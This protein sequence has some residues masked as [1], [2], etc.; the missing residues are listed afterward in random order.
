EDAH[1]ADVL[2]V[3]VCLEAYAHRAVHSHDVADV[4]LLPALQN[5]QDASISSHDYVQHPHSRPALARFDPVSTLYAD[6]RQIH[7][8]VQKYAPNHLDA[9][10]HRQMY[11]SQ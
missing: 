7:W 8:Q 3:D 2:V 6:P 5:L 9:H 1:L 4:V 10:R 11:R